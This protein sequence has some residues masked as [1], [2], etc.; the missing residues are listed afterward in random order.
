MVLEN[1]DGDKISLRFL[2]VFYVTLMVLCGKVSSICRLL[3]KIG[4]WF[5]MIVL[6]LF[7]KGLYCVIKSHE[8]EKVILSNLGFL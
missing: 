2:F 3:Y 1:N 6:R 8:V 7:N 5:L 4:K